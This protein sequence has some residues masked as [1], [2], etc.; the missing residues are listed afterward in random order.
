MRYGNIRRGCDVVGD[1]WWCYKKRNTYATTELSGDSNIFQKKTHKEVK[2]K[3]KKRDAADG[4]KGGENQNSPMPIA[5]YSAN[6]TKKPEAKQT[7]HPRSL[8]K[9]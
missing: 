7:P 2:K 4:K 3:K 9:T 8:K 6:H 5:F 1:E